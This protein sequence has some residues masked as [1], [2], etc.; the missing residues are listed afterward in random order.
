MPKIRWW[1]AV[2]LVA[3]ALVTLLW[4]Q[5]GESSGQEKTMSSIALLLLVVVLLLGW[6]L[7]FSRLPW[8]RRALV[9]AVVVGLAGILAAT[10]EIRGVT[11]N[12]M[13]VLAWRWSQPAQPPAIT[14]ATT[15][16]RES[17]PAAGP[18]PAAPDTT[19][20]V[21]IEGV[22][23]LPTEGSSSQELVAEAS[24]P[25]GS[26]SGEAEE[27]RPEADATASSQAAV[28]ALLDQDYPGFLGARRDGVVRGVRLARDW[29]T[30]PPQQLW[31]QPIGPAWSGFAIAGQV[32]VTQEQRG[33]EELVTSYDLSTGALR[34]VH[35]SAGRYESTIAGTGPRATPTVA[36]NRVYAQGALGRL[37][38]LDRDTGRLVW[39][40]DLVAEHDAEIPEWGKSGSPLVVDDLV[41]VSAGGRPGHS[42]VAYDAATGEPVW[43]AGDDRSSYSSPLLATLAG[44]RQVVILNQGSVAGHDPADGRILWQLPWP[45]EQPSVAV[46]VVLPND[47]LFVSAGYGIGGKVAQLERG[48]GEN[49]L[50]ARWVWET[51]RLKA[52]FTNVV[53]HQ[54]SLYGLDDGTLVCLDPITGERRWKQGR[55]GHGQVVLVDDLLVVQTERGEIV[56]IEPNPEELRELGRFQALSGKTWNPPAF[57]AGVLLVRHDSEVVSYR[58]ALEQLPRN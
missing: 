34:W 19:P 10:L 8:R 27:V 36:G 40:R 58:L 16:D 22:A 28:V 7:L 17:A 37:S 39:T 31:R 49:E 20:T 38:V 29:K 47:Q 2:V 35:A 43:H 1:P 15:E 46:P 45:S 25:G 13:P 21:Q 30:Q 23:P 5:L 56:L 4:I 3:L 54:G 57:A 41:I 12:L 48:E 53:F 18:E 52:K 50:R 33:D 55:Y 26:G 44:R 42:L 9:T 6:V 24:A 11:G 51:P 32:A 14:A